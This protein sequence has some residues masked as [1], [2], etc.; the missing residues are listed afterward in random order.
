VDDANLDVGGLVLRNA[1][2]VAG[3]RCRALDRR[4]E[5]GGAKG[6]GGEVAA[7]RSAVTRVTRPPKRAD[8]DALSR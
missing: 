4:L 5:A 6:D 1:E 8:R 7:V 2:E 3:D